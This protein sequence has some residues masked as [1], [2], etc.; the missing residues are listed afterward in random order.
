VVNGRRW[1]QTHG[2]MYNLFGRS[3]LLV[4]KA[5]KSVHTGIMRT[6]SRRVQ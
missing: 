3:G 6:P 1:I 2:T 4:K 5:L